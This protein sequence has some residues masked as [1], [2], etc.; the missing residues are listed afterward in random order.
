MQQVGCGS[1]VGPGNGSESGGDSCVVGEAVMAFTSPFV[2][3][4]V[5]RTCDGA[6]A[7]VRRGAYLDR[8]LESGSEAEDFNVAIE[9]VRSYLDDLSSSH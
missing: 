2:L 7:L 3:E 8:F 1:R 6:A 5:T 4:E 9:I